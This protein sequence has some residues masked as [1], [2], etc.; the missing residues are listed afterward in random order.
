MINAKNVITP[1]E[2]QPPPNRFI[3]IGISG[4][5]TPKTPI[6]QLLWVVMYCFTPQFGHFL[7]PTK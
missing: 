4:N 6:C 2:T 7:C 3:V 5:G 1:E